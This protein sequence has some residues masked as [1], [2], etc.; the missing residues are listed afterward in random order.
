[1]PAFLIN[2]AIYLVFL[3]FLTAFAVVIPLP[4]EKPVCK[5]GTID[6]TEGQYVTVLMFGYVIM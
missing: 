2:L 4:N 5:G 6:C 1:M 3:A